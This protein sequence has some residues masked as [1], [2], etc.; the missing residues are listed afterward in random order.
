MNNSKFKNKAFL[1]CILILGACATGPTL[2]PTGTFDSGQKVVLDR[3]WS[4][5][6]GMWRVVDGRILPSNKKVKTLTID[7]SDLNS[8]YISQGL[9][10]EDPLMIGP[11]GNSRSNPSPRPSNNMSLSEQIEYVGRSMTEAGYLHV[12][13]KSPRPV[14]LSGQ[15]GVRFELNMRNSAGL[16]IS[17]L[18]QAVNKGGLN[19]YIVYIAPSEYYYQSHLDNVIKTMDSATLP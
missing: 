9:G 7:G 10:S 6:T 8:L 4:D 2:A 3:N 15:R 18:A 19:Y 13:T 12:E 14:N 5:V 1:A 17:G 11:N 16:N